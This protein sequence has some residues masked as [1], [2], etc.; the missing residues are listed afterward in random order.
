VAAREDPRGRATTAPTVAQLELG[1][2]ALVAIR[3]DDEPDTDRGHAG[4]L[5][6]LEPERLRD[7]ERGRETKP[8]VQV[9][10]DCAGDRQ[11]DEVGD[12]QERVEQEEDPEADEHVDEREPIE[13]RERH[14]YVRGYADQR[15]RHREEREHEAGEQ[16]REDLQLPDAIRLALLHVGDDG[17]P[18][19]E[20][21]AVRRAA[22]ARRA[23]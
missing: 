2:A 7:V 6:H 10:R 11:E 1:D 23:V 16:T 19:I 14:A 18:G 4:D 21:E 20:V 15:A 5:D 12:G 8:V 17:Q 3:A 13:A 22:D 9:E